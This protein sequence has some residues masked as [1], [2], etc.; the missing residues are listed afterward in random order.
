VNADRIALVATVI[1]LV[2]SVLLVGEWKG[3]IQAQQAQTTQQVGQLQAAVAD[4]DQMKDD[5]ARTAAFAEWVFCKEVQQ[6]PQSECAKEWA[7]KAMA[8]LPDSTAAVP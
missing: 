3:T 7:A 8:L 5:Q 2:G 1:G 6:R 4:L